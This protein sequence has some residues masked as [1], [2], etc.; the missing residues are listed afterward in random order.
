MGN[1]TKGELVCMFYHRSPAPF[2]PP[3]PAENLF[4]DATSDAEAQNQVIGCGQ[5]GVWSKGLC[6]GW[7]DEHKFN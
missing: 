2:T 7:S 5:A 4:R 3:P 1:H 6:G